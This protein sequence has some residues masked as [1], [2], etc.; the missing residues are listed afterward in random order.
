MKP[1]NKYMNI[2]YT[3]HNKPVLI[4]V[5]KIGNETM[6]LSPRRIKALGKATKPTVEMVDGE[7]MLTC[8]KHEYR[9]HEN[10]SA[11]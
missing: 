8:H 10:V 11:L 4:E 1:Y 6:V 3:W 7:P 9:P 5:V 2:E